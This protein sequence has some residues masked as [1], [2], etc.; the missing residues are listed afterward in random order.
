VLVALALGSLRLIPGR[1][2]PSALIALLAALPLMLSGCLQ[3]GHVDIFTVSMVNDTGS[4]VVL[5]DCDN[6]CS[7]SPLVFDLAPGSSVDV[8]RITNDHKYFSIT[9]PSGGH[10]GCLD[11]YFKVPEPGAH[12][13]VSQA[14]RCP[15]GFR[16]P[17][18]PIGLAGL[19]LLPLL[20]L[21]L[22]RR[23]FGASRSL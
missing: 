16:L 14:V 12:M 5:R 22:G 2:V 6:Y 21:L 15:G 13:P 1:L 10:L 17:W 9:T 20:A 4:S 19:V 3:A 18:K 8:H 23:A 7:S 11:L